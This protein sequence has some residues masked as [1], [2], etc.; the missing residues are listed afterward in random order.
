MQILRK[1]AWA[2]CLGVALLA[3][4]ALA[5]DTV[6]A[7]VPYSQSI[8]LEGQP[9]QLNGAGVRYKAVL[10]VYA[11]GLYLS[12]R[13]NTPEQ[14]YA[15]SGPK[16]ITF[17]LLREVNS[18]E[19]GKAFTRGFEDNAPKEQL[20]RLIPGLIQLG[21]IFAAQKKLVAGETVS[22]DWIPGTGTVISVRG[23]AQ[24][25]PIPEPE[26]F[27]AML[28]IWL[29]QQPADWKLKDALLGKT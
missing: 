4:P 28:R 17:T 14:A 8:A 23:L 27:V 12:A 2:W 19:L 5:Q 3:G 10:K 22:V 21:D 18:A 7:D 29:G 25:K 11:I 1:C 13:A 6:V 20:S 9:L 16:R 26:F 24:G 15:A